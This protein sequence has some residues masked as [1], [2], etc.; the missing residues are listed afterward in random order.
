MKQI[1]CKLTFSN[2]VAVIALFIALGGASY[3]ATQ[4]PKNSVGTRQ[5]R[6]DAVTPAKLS[7]AA[8]EAL[9]GPKGKR[10][11]QGDP[12]TTG[13]PGPQG[14]PGRSAPLV[15]DATGGGVALPD[16]GSVSIPL[17]GDFS[18]VSQA[19]TAG[20]LLAEGTATLASPT[21]TVPPAPP[22]ECAFLVSI[23]DGAETL[24]TGVFFNISSDRS[25]AATLQSRDGEGDSSQ[26]G[27]LK[28]GVTHTLSARLNAAPDFRDDCAPGSKLDALRIT[29]AEL[30]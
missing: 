4:L 30:G 16:T 10:G 2:V 19:N 13:Q 25:G 24:I 12:G 22:E 3:A 26:L 8:K 14:Q 11:P 23:Y 27:V 9:E 7:N 18:W 5:I 6:D 29:V 17:A 20:L 21:E 1:R 28:P 15:I